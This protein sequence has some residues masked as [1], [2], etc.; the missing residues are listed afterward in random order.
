M[1][2]QSCLGE[3]I[4]VEVCI[5]V[6]WKRNQDFDA[7]VHLFFLQEPALT[8]TESRKKGMTLLVALTPEGVARGD[9]FW[10]DGEGLLTFEKGDYTQILFLARNVSFWKN[11][12][13]PKNG[14]VLVKRCTFSYAF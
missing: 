9:L 10:D 4:V 2:L 5:C 11:N 8:T 7:G 13:D 14:R 6:S 12:S 3:G 1:L